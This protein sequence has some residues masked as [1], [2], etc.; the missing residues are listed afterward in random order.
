[1]RGVTEPIG[2]A[3]IAGVIQGDG[4][5]IPLINKF[6][7]FLAAA[8]D[9]VGAVVFDERSFDPEY[10]PL[11]ATI[12]VVGKDV[13][14]VVAN[15]APAEIIGQRIFEALSI[16]RNPHVHVV[17]AHNLGQDKIELLLA[18]LVHTFPAAL[19]L[20]FANRGTGEEA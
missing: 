3:Y 11:D 5:R 16:H 10:R 4:L 6:A 14:P 19:R 8:N 7:K 2:G 12:A 9:V 1:M 20:A 13:V 15:V 17:L 18:D